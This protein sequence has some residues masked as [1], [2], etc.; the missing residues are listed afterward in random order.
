MKKFTIG[1]GANRLLRS[2]FRRWQ[3]QATSSSLV[4]EMHEEGAV[5][6]EEANYRSELR[7]IKELMNHE[8]YD[9]QDITKA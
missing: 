4:K 8:G 3:E 6:I 9:D 7:N 2:G 1:L 5:R